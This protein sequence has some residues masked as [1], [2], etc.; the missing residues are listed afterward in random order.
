MRRRLGD[1]PRAPLATEL[2]WAP[3]ERGLRTL[4]GLD[5]VAVTRGPRPDGARRRHWQLPP[6]R[7]GALPWCSYE[8][9]V[10]GPIKAAEPVAEP[11]GQ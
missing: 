3:V 7:R 11:I 6:P 8:Q 9:L 10:N 2:G 1:R 5:S 4:G